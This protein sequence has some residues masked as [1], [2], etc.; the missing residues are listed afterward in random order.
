MFAA[1]PTTTPPT[2][3]PLTT[4]PPTV[5]DV[6]ARTHVGGDW[7]EWNADG[8]TIRITR[9]ELR[10]ALEAAHDPS[11]PDWPAT[12]EI[13]P[14]YEIQILDPRHGW[15]NWPE[16]LGHGFDNNRWATEAEAQAAIDDLAAAGFDTNR[17]RVALAA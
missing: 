17:L 10:P 6:L 13:A 4:T 16:H 11:M 14:A 15:I 1:M 5:G 3:T 12:V 9:A 8:G 7:H 2:T